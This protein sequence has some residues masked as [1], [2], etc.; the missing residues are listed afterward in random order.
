MHISQFKTYTPNNNRKL[1]GEDKFHL[2]LNL[3]FDYDLPLPRRREPEEVKTITR[4]WTGSE[5]RVT[6]IG[7]IQEF[8]LLKIKCKAGT[9]LLTQ[10][11][12]QRS[13]K[14]RKQ[15]RPVLHNGARPSE[16]K[17]RRSFQ[18]KSPIRRSDDECRESEKQGRTWIQT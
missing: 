8:P 11:K 10:C 1:Q 18:N 12:C 5:G 15:G 7:H 13:I 4:T 16:I 3:N 9:A 14:Q 6:Y 17:R 2:L